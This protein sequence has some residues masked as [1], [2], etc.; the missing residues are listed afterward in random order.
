[1]TPLALRDHARQMLQ[2]IALDMDTAQSPNE[3]YVKSQGRATPIASSETAA[4]SHGTL[5]QLR[6]F[7]LVQ[8]NAEFRALRATVLRL[9][10]PRV[11]VLDD[12]STRDMIRFNETIDQ[13]LAEAIVTYSEKAARSRDTFLAILG[14]DLRSPLQ[15]MAMAGEYLAHRALNETLT[16][17]VG[18]RVRRSTATMT[19]MVNDLLEY[20]RSQLGG[21]L[22]IQR[23]PGDLAQV[24]RWAV[25]DVG[26]AHPDCRFELALD[27]ELDGRFDLARIQQ[28]LSNLLNNAVQYRGPGEPVELCALGTSTQ[29][30]LKV[31]NTGPVIPPAS[32]SAIFDPLVQ[33]AA[34]PDQH[35][36][37]W[38]SLGL[39]L[40]IAREIAAG[41]G[42]AIHATSS[43]DAGTVFTVTLPKELEPA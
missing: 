6:G 19:S 40:F 21:E 42:G 7:S 13:A 1:M 2:A 37:P 22:P 25:E 36:R 26:V 23:Q 9:W 5:R 15:T 27:G 38:T 28:L 41:H 35:G 16:R 32:L 11:K 30:V 8:L 29:L 43:V 24:C 31:R 20:A 12:A 34:V 3:Q 33:L 10:L 18:A 4:S 14:H 17:E 39:G